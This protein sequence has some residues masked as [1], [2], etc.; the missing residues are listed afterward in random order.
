M[1]VEDAGGVRVAM[2]RYSHDRLDGAAIDY[3]TEKEME[4]FLLDHPDAAFAAF[5]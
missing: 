4:G 5:C 1:I 2:D 3:D